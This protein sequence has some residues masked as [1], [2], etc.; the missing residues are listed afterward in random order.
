MLRKKVD[1]QNTKLAEQ[2]H[3]TK[4]LLLKT[5]RREML[6]TLTLQV[7][8]STQTGKKYAN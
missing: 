7:I 2:Q 5:D 1:L 6:N 4:Q 3:P 8:L